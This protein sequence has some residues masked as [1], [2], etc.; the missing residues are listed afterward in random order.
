GRVGAKEAPAARDG[1]AAAVWRPR[2]AGAP[3]WCWG[4]PRPRNNRRIER[5]LP[6]RINRRLH[7]LLAAAICRRVEHLLPDD[8]RCHEALRTAEAVAE[9]TARIRSLEPGHNAAGRVDESGRPAAVG[10]ALPAVHWPRRPA[11]RPPAP[12]AEPGGPPG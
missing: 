11:G 2:T 7:Y 8:P 3:L 12:R 10:A 6:K 4:S 1:V 5:V 9:G